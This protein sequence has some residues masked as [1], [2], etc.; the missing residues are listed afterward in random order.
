MPA[1]RGRGKGRGDCCSKLTFVGDLL[2]SSL[3]GAGDCRGEQQASVCGRLL[4]KPFV[5]RVITAR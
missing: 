1:A 3:C 5:R 4:A 2:R